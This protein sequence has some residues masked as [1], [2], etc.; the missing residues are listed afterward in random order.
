MLQGPGNQRFHILQ[1]IVQTIGQFRL[2]EKNMIRLRQKLIY[3]VVG[4]LFTIIGYLLATLT[5]D[6]NAQDEE[7]I[8]HFDAITCR[9][10][11]VLDEEG[12]IVIG[13]VADEL[14]G[15]LFV[16]DKNQKRSVNLGINN[17]SGHIGIA[18]SDGNPVAV[19]G[20]IP[21][22]EGI[23]WTTEKSGQLATWTSNPEEL[24]KAIQTQHGLD[25]DSTILGIGAKLSPFNQDD[26]KLRIGIFWDMSSI[27]GVKN[28]EIVFPSDGTGEII[29]YDGTHYTSP[30]GCTIRNFTIISGSLIVNK[31][32]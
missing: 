6:L 8:Q 27:N 2:K 20:A 26:C 11:G 16:S 30:K 28:N 21:S 18:N 24:A 32:K 19:I 4:S 10:F 23:I 25:Q 17:D 29:L 22:G 12:K 14:G 1:K 13:L 9:A 3:M 5:A 31:L 15:K 7:K